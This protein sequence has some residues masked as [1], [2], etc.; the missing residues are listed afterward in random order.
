MDS[1]SNEEINNFRKANDEAIIAY[2]K[3]KGVL[4]Y[5]DRK[6]K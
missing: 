4:E 2:A 5:D 6:I 3:E 1:I